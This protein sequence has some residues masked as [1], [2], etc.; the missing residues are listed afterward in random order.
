[1]LFALEH[2]ERGFPAG[3]TGFCMVWVWSM[4]LSLLHFYTQSFW[5]GYFVHILADLVNIFC[6]LTF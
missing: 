2:Y 1:M 5:A 4:V 6:N 3:F